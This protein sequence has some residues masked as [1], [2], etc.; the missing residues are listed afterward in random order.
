ME[1]QEY[2]EFWEMLKG[3][4]NQMLFES[5]GSYKPISY[6]QMYSAVYKCVCKQYSDQLYADLICHMRT[7]L[8]QWT[9]DLNQV[10]DQEFILKFHTYLDRYFNALG[11]IVPIFTYMNRF[12]IEAKLH[13]DLNTELTRLFKDLVADK[14]VR[15]VVNLMVLARS[16]PFSVPPAVMA[17]LCRKL[18]K[19]NPEYNTIQPGLFSSYIP[20]VG[21][22]MTEEDL[23]AQMAQDRALQESLRAQGWGSPGSGLCGKRDLEE[24]PGRRGEMR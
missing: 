6:E 8:S 1:P 17:E 12:Y 7:R 23:Q 15:R 24:E 22:R 3:A 18:H 13:T 11:G 20:N 5:P 19:L 16:Q 14:H 9:G 2:K 21:P 10:P 4:V